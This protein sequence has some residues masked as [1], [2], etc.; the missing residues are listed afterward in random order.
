MAQWLIVDLCVGAYSIAT[1]VKVGLNI[2]SSVLI[3]ERLGLGPY[4]VT[5]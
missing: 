2:S 1:I 5:D 3:G 4:F